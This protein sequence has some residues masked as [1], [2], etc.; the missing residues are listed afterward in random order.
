MGLL[1][2]WIVADNIISYQKYWRFTETV[3]TFVGSVVI[4]NGPIEISTV[5]VKRQYIIYYPSSKKTSTVH[6]V[7]FRRT[8][9]IRTTTGS[10]VLALQ[11]PNNTY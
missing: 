3:E 4:D 8:R 9:R 10:F 2:D 5:S 11:V 6:E 7:L 1:M